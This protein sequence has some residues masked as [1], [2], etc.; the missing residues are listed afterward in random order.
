MSLF[1]PIYLLTHLL[2]HLFLSQ[3]LSQ[4]L[5]HTNLAILAGS[6]S[7]CLWP[8]HLPALGWQVCAA[9]HGF[10]TSPGDPNSSPQVCPS[11]LPPEPFS[12]SQFPRVM[13]YNL[14]SQV[15]QIPKKANCVGIQWWNM[16]GPCDM[17][18]GAQVSRSKVYTGQQVH[19][20]GRL[21][22]NTRLKVSAWTVR[23]LTISMA[24]V[25]DQL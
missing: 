11:A 20:Y 2:T 10:Y 16:E 7:A 23:K 13:S 14:Q 3:D 9:L 18:H 15:H 8:H 6:G 1:L 22:I 24:P 17:E 25:C 21:T 4:K 5:K 19:S 12:R